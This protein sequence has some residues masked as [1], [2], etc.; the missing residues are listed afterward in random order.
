MYTT[1]EP[2]VVAPVKYTFALNVNTSTELG[3]RLMVEPFTAAL[4]RLEAAFAVSPK[5]RN[6][7]TLPVL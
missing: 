2:D 3:T 4:A 7:T 5:P 6:T 1:A